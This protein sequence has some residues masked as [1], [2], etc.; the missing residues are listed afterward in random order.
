[1]SLLEEQEL[2]YY[3]RPTTWEP[4]EPFKPGPFLPIYPPP[5]DLITP[6]PNPPLRATTED[7]TVFTNLGFRHSSHIVPA[8]FLRSSP[9]HPL[10]EQSPS[11]L[12][13]EEQSKRNDELYDILLN[14]RIAQNKTRALYQP[15]QPVHGYRRVLWNCVDRFVRVS[16]G[17]DGVT[18]ILLHATGFSKEMWEPFLHFFLRSPEVRARVGEIWSFEA[19]HHG[20]SAVINSAVLESVGLSLWEDE[21]RDMVQF[22]TH[23]LPSQ[24][25]DLELPTVLSPISFSEKQRRVADGLPKNRRVIAITHSRA[26]CTS[27]LA[28]FHFPKLF[29]SLLLTDPSIYRPRIP[30]VYGL[31]GVLMKSALIRRGTWSCREDAI[32]QFSRSPLFQL[33]HP[34]SLQNYLNHGLYASADGKVHLKTS[35]LQECIAYSDIEVAYIVWTLLPSLDKD[36]KLCYVMPDEPSFGLDA[37]MSQELVWLR[38][39]NC[40]NIKMA[41]AGHLIPQEKPEEYG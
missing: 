10:P 2:S 25:S 36:I 8:C 11:G 23:Y 7:L 22:L 41:G 4:H 32:A 1:M 40:S 35:P 37:V 12:T 39:E 15:G 17:S 13:R 14:T 27:A 34:S 5:E 21:S 33:W 30:D 20:S 24:W 19:V 38:P 6:A 26:G 9:P 16:G 29:S 28:A 18:L 3:P 31:L